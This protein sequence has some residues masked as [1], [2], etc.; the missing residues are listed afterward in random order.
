VARACRAGVLANQT[1]A[2]GEAGD[3]ANTPLALEQVAVD[4][5]AAFDGEENTIRGALAS[6]IE[7]GDSVLA[8]NLYP[9]GK[10][11]IVILGGP[12]QG[13]S[14]IS[15]LLCQLYRVAMLASQEPS[16]IVGEVRQAAARMRT[17]FDAA[18]LPK[19]TLS[20][21][22]I[23]AALSGYADDISGGADVS[24]RRYLTQIVNRRASE[25]LSDAEMRRLLRVW[26][27]AIVLDGLDEVASP[28]VRVDVIDRITEFMGETAAINADVLLVCTSRSQ[29]FENALPGSAA[30]KPQPAA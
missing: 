1:V 7:R 8:P 14:T 21:V 26:P 30:R 25:H 19:P 10:S 24:L 5:L 9:T 29:G 15:R 12:G 17:A 27:S 28:S 4:L 18:A 20:R 6:I 11:R 2:L 22:P 13:K 3:A 23:Y 16:S